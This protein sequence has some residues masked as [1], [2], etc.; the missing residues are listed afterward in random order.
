MISSSLLVMLAVT[1]AFSVAASTITTGSE[2]ECG[3]LTEARGLFCPEA[4]VAFTTRID[5]EQAALVSGIVFHQFIGDDDSKVEVEARFFCSDKASNL[6]TSATQDEPIHSFTFTAD[7]DNDDTCVSV[8]LPTPLFLPASC[9]LF[10][11]LQALDGA[12]S[13]GAFAD[14]CDG[15]DIGTTSTSFITCS[16]TYPQPFPFTAFRG[17]VVIGVER[18][19]LVS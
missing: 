9:V 4:S 1:V 8:P 5:I 12:S 10:V 3:A 16:T 2:C 14:E 13:I 7:S 19:F 17:D 18:T 15:E 11:E 6:K